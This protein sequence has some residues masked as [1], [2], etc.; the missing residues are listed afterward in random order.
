MT[1]IIDLSNEK[2]KTMLTSIELMNLR[3]QHIRERRIRKGS[4][5]CGQVLSTASDNS[6]IELYP[7]NDDMVI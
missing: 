1:R 7:E 5:L 4:I 3:R 2:D 6:I